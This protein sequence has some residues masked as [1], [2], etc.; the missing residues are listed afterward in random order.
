MGANPRFM[1]IPLDAL[2]EALD[3]VLDEARV[4]VCGIR[5]LTRSFI[6]KLRV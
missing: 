4:C 2:D 5:S 6:T 3:D 1:H